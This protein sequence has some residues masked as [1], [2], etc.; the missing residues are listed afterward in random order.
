MILSIILIII[1]VIIVKM[2]V[3]IADMPI[4]DGQILG[5]LMASNNGRSW[6]HHHCCGSTVKV[7]SVFY[8]SLHT[9]LVVMD[10]IIQ[11]L[12]DAIQVTMAELWPPSTSKRPPIYSTF[13]N[14]W[15]KWCIYAL[16]YYATFSEFIWVKPKFM[17]SKTKFILLIKYLCDQTNNYVS[18]QQNSFTN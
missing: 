18:S 11:D 2:N 16:K 17:C 14:L 3:D 13:S 12:E 15:L 6:A 1:I 10:E 4:P 5:F 8:F 7:G 9:L